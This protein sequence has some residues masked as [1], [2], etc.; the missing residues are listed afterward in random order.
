M[1]TISGLK[2]IGVKAIIVG[3]AL[4]GVEKAKEICVGGCRSSP[5][6]AQMPSNGLNEVCTHRVYGVRTQR[7]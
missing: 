3:V 2:P 6:C 1:P 4:G 5:C 7:H